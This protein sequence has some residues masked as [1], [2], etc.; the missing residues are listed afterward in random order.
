MSVY[1]AITVAERDV[2]ATLDVRTGTGLALVGANG[3]GKTTLIEA[4][5]GLIDVTE[6]E[7]TLDGDVVARTAS[8]RREPARR[9]T[10]VPLRDRHIALLGQDSALFPHLT[11][12]ENVAFPLRARGA[13]RAVATQRAHALLGTVGASDIAPARPRELSG[14]QARRVALAR[15][16]ASEPRLVLLDEPFAG[17]DAAS[18][19]ALRDAVARTTSHLTRIIATHDPFDAL[20]LADEIAVMEGGRIVAQGPSREL[21]ARPRHATVAAMS[22]KVWM[23]GTWTGRAL[24][25]QGATVPCEGGGLAVGG[26]AAVALDPADLAIVDVSQ[27]A[28][29]TDTVM[30]WEP[31]PGG[32]VRVAGALAWVLVAFDDPALAALAPGAPLRL[33]LVR[34][35]HAYALEPAPSPAAEPS[36]KPSGK[37]QRR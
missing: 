24:N 19:A 16:L 11:A 7:I 34:P 3:S 29:L 2:A 30:G 37:P 20:H 26:A 1:A 8:A 22:G 6:A 28:D 18:V 31:A 9:A 32:R 12:A 25:V 21:L 4:I 36:A 17:I 10:H 14:G 5:A 33:R 27:E 35:Q 23:P 15:A 13:R